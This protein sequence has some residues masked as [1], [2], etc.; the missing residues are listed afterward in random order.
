[1]PSAMSHGD[2]LLVAGGEDDEDDPLLDIEIYNGSSWTTKHLCLPCNPGPYMKSA[3]L[4]GNWYLSGFSSDKA[5]YSASLDSLITMASSMNP[6]ASMV[7]EKLPDVPEY[8]SVIPVVF[9]NHLIALGQCSKQFFSSSMI[10]AYSVDTCSWESVGD[11][12]LAM[13]CVCAET[14]RSRDLIIIGEVGDMNATSIVLK[15]TVNSKSSC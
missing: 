10:Y 7:W 3:C 13:N 9:K 8:W 5:V 4:D 12:R 1:M 6:E 2:Y 14:M 11:L 15:A